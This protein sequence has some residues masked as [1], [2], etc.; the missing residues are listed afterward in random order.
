MKL[1]DYIADFLVNH[2]IDSV[3][4]VVGGG[5]MHLNDSFGHNDG[6]HCTYHHHEQAA[7]IA[8]EGYAKLKCKPAVVCVTSG[9][10]ATNAITGVAGAWVDSIPMIV[11][12]GQTKS[13][14]T[15]ESSGLPLRCLGNQ[16][17][18]IVPVVKP[19]TKNAVMIHK[20]EEIRRELEKALYLSCLLYT[21]DAAD[22][23]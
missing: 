12:S 13:T 15:I 23:L 1:S 4:T 19:I 11:I 16:E 21:S 10:G 2:G 14:L 9:P 3:F 6:L 20:P 7:A 22:E 8:A 18:D 17:I 5:A